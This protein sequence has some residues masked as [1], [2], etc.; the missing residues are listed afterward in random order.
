MSL[1]TAFR[2][3]LEEGIH[4]PDENWDAVKP[5]LKLRHYK[6]NDVIIREKITFLQLQLA[7]YA[8]M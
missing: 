7:V 2:N 8:T 6:K 5:F 1:Y 3:A 4:I